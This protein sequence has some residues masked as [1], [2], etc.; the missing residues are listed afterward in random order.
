[1]GFFDFF[2]R[3]SASPATPPMAQSRR[4][5]MRYFLPKWLRGD[6]TL[7][8]SELIFSAVSRIS[9]ALSAMPV[10]LY[11][12][13]NAQKTSL[14]DLVNAVPNPNMTACQFFKTME[15]CRCT[16]GNAYALKIVNARMQTERLDVIDPSRVTPVMD[17]ASR[18]LWY[19]IQPEM[20]EAYY[21][22]NYYVLHIPFI[23]TNGY[24]GINP[25]DVLFDTLAYSGAIKKFSVDQLDKG[26]NASIVLEAPAGLG[27]EQKESMINDML[28]TY[29]ETGGDIV[30][31]ES[32]VTAKTLNLSPVDSKLFEVEKITRGK[33][34]MVYN[35]PPHLLGDYSD[36]SFST[37]EQ[38]M[39][40]FSTLTLLPIVTA[41]EQEMNKKLLTRAQRNRGYFFKFN[42]DALLRADAKTK[43]EVRQKGVRGGWLMINEIR[44]EDGRPRTKDGDVPLVSKD[45]TTLGFIVNNPEKTYGGNNSNVEGNEDSQLPEDEDDIAETG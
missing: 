14:N 27:Q 42:M 40:E 45:L 1:M 41:Y 43:A 35:L 19:Q 33:V 13:T 22:H 6:Y 34:A 39:L 10:N 5:G 18:E 30:L 44:A 28:D 16:Y 12:G 31:L 36:T 17:T 7:Q 3:K 26:V 25:V 29:K 32:G 2:K 11:K 4:P 9:N 38:Q 24:S 23:S 20:G 8:N 21:I 15:A 37:L